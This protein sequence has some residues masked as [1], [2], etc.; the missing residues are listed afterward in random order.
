MTIA[1]LEPVPTVDLAKAMTSIALDST[2]DK[3]RCSE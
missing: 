1:K 3:G 2:W